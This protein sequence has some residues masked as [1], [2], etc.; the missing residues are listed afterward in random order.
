MK[1]FIFILVVALMHISAFGQ[2]K[3]TLNVKTE[4][5]SKTK[6]YLEIYN[7]KNFIPIKMDSFFVVNGHHTIN[8][9]LK[10]P[11]NFAAFF[12]SYKGKLITTHFVLD[13]G[14]NNVSL[15]TP[16]TEYKSLTLHSSARGHFIFSDLR[17]LYLEIANRYREPATGYLK[18]PPDVNGQI[19][20]MEL[21]R[22]E[23]YP[24]DFGSLIYLYRMSRMNA[25]PSFAK[26]N[27]ATLAK[28]SD[29]LKNS[30][31][32]KQL[33]KEETSLINNKILA[34]SGNTVKT[35]TV[36]DINNKPFSNNSLK[37]QPYVI[38]FSATWC[39]PCQRQLPKLK[40]LYD[41][42]K[43]KGLKVI[44]FNDDDNVAKWKA[45]VSK[46]KLTWINAS[47][48]VKPGAGKIQKSFGVYSIPTCVVVDKNGT[49]VYNSDQSDPDIQLIETFL[50]RVI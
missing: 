23:T 28:F 30:N 10:Q 27:L 34:G 35:F 40:K 15:D 5:L 29:E 41:A 44:Y 49:I 46:N 24:N 22:L 39:G 13:S 50:K 2:Y 43:K 25:I 16:I 4:A 38:V 1:K 45:H 32:G 12:V 11:S 21:M 36:K 42:Y 48:R 33:Y 14:K 18:I 17:N 3:F 37:G 47:E 8:G 31:L 20:K 19:T 26:D 9:E 7:N 6:I